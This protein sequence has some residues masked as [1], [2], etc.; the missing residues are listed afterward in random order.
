M[1]IHILPDRDT[2]GKPIQRIEAFAAK[3]VDGLKLYKRVHGVKHSCNIGNNDIYFTIPYDVC[4]ITGAEFINAE[5]GDTADLWILDTATG[6]ITTIPNYPL[7]QF[8][9][10]VNLA[11]D[12]YEHKSEYD[13]SLQLGL[14]IWVKY[15]S[16]SI[17]E[18]GI[19][20]ILNELKP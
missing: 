12:H 7:N 10:L 20:F 16:I 1:G 4:K 15:N 9:F 6:T 13:A 5:A 2:T 14:Q 11:K 18:V 8:G 3:S 17:K 19:N